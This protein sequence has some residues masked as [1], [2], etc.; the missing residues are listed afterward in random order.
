MTHVTVPILLYHEIAASRVNHDKPGLVVGL[1]DFRWQMY[2]LK[3]LGY[4]TVSLDDLSLALQGQ[5]HRSRLQRSFIITFDD[6]YSGAYEFGFPLL[7]K[8]GYAAT[9]FL[10]V[11]DFMEREP[12]S[13]RAFPVLSVSQL[14]EMAQADFK[15]G[16]HSLTHP[17][18]NT[19]PLN[20]SDEISNSKQILEQRFN[21]PVT[22]FAYPYGEY[23]SDLIKLVK[24]SGYDS[25]VTTQIG[26]SHQSEERFSL[27]RIG[28]GANQRFWHFIYRFFFSKNQGA[29]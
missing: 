26:R 7:K 23:N 22:S 15:I 18:L 13:S 20:W 16:S 29:G 1:E 21:L 17:H 3:S 4:H 10:I 11:E 25:A 28:V 6:G 14:T 12:K 19:L 27:R 5:Q 2:T 8:L 9:V 24:A